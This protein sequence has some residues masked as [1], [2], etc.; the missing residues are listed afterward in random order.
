MENTP[1]A[2]KLR[3]KKLSGFIGQEHLVGN[4][5]IIKMSSTQE[6]IVEL[7]V[8]GLLYVKQGLPERRLANLISEKNSVSLKDAVK[9][10][11]LN[12]NE[13]KAALGVLKKKAA[14]NLINEKF[15]I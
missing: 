11:G 4:K 7:G 14:I 9:Q 8:N 12:E 13:F 10:S 5:G 1:L 15:M 3:P 2:E 6:H